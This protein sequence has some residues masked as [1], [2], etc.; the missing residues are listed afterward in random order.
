[1]KNI[2]ETKPSVNGHFAAVILAVTLIC[3]SGAA[4]AGRSRGIDIIDF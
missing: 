1:M 3:S 4:A 2:V